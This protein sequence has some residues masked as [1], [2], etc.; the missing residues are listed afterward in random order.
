MTLLIDIYSLLLSAHAI[1][2]PSNKLGLGIFTIALIS[3][4]VLLLAGRE[5]SSATARNIK[6][7]QKQRRRMIK[8]HEAKKSNY[9]EAGK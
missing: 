1:V 4:G 7:I 6:Q 9:K 8:A 5:K 3:A 2:V